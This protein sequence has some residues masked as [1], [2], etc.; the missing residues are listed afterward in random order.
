MPTHEE[1]ANLLEDGTVA[2][3]RD[4]TPP[5]PVKRQVPTLEYAGVHTPKPPPYLPPQLSHT[6]AFVAPLG[7]PARHA[8]AQ[9]KSQ[10]KPTLRYSVTLDEEKRPFLSLPLELLRPANAI[11]MGIVCIGL[12]IVPLFALLAFGGA[13][14]LA[15]FGLVLV[16]IIIAHYV[17]VIDETGPEARDELPPPLREVSFWDDFVRPLM[18]LTFALTVCF[19]PSVWLF[20]LAGWRTDSMAAVVGAAL[21]AIAYP[22]FP[23]V[24]LT[25]VTGTTPLNLAPHRLLKVMAICGVPYLVATLVLLPAAVVLHGLSALMFAEAVAS[26]YELSILRPAATPVSPWLTLPAGGALL[27]LAVYAGHLFP[28]WLGRLY[29][30]HHDQFPW[31][32]Q[33]HERREPREPERSSRVPTA[34]AA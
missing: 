32:L 22:F 14:P 7:E 24:L 25:T 33:R 34:A 28:W 12:L 5:P 13:F 31:L 18:Q 27:L 10:R 2:L 9:R 15:A 1:A 17:S 16:L 23:A 8:P 29:R 30:R 26:A 11:V 19:G 3:A 20:S 21:A 4:E 6:S